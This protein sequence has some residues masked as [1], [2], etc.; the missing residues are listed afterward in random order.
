MHVHMCSFSFLVRSKLRIGLICNPD[1][2]LFFYCNSA[3]FRIIVHVCVLRQKITYFG[4]K[5]TIPHELNI[6]NN[7]ALL[8][9]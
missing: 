1:I 3:D 8:S 9:R 4:V 2:G 7:C 5:Y 6:A